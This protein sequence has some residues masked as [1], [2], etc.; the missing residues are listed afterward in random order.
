MS[1]I[2]KKVLVVGGGTAGWITAGLIAATHKSIKGNTIEVA[3]VESPNIGP[4]GV[5]EGTWPTMRNTLI[6][7]GISET[8]FMRCCDASFK[9]AS[10]FVGWLDGSDAYYHPFTIPAKYIESNLASRWQDIRNKISF[11]DAFSAQANICELGLAPKQ[12][13]TPE[14][15]GVLNYGYHLDSLKFSELL[16]KHA[17]Q[18][19][20]VKHILDDVVGVNALA[21]GD[22]ES[23]S[24]QANGVITADLFID[25]TGF[26]SRLIGEHFGVGLIDVKNSL[27]VDSA[28]AVQV[29]YPVTNENIASHTLS[30]ALPAG[31]VWDI[32][33]PT[34]R[35]VGYVYSSSHTSDANAE[36]DLSAYAKTLGVSLD[37]LSPRKIAINS[38]YRA[39]PW[40]RNCVAVGLAAGFVEPLEASSLVMV[41]LAAKLISEELPA[42]HGVM[43][44]TAKKF[45]ALFRYRWE[46]IIDFLK[47]HYVLSKRTDSD[48]WVDNRSAET[49]PDSLQD[50]LDVWQYRSP[51]HDDFPQRDEIFSAASYQYVLYGMG[52]NTEVRPYLK[53]ENDYAL[54][55][56]S[57]KE[58]AALTEKLKGGLPSNR[59]LLSKIKTFGLNKI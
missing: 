26:S 49:I 30:T 16:K 17:Q 15:A 8:E 40:V 42:T 13:A 6:K 24:T 59:E 21:S 31:W 23:V 29:P 25:C 46:K 56:N 57:V 47:L 34:R 55:I 20:G 19:L 44:P 41:E 33:L 45:N 12:I 18:A 4:V 5:G 22:I 3:L 51:W 54:L 2:I 50:L 39:T 1:K 37:A 53:T 35:G 11:A 10:K 9:Q 58:M 7:L 36:A 48:F 38:G 14:Y 43:A 27:F 32:G 52:F 28:L